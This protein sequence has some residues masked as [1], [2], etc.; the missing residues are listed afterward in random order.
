MK[1]ETLD[2]KDYEK[3]VKTTL[4]EGVCSFIAVHNTKR[5]PALGGIRFYPYA[6]EKEALDDALNLA[7]AMTYKAS[8]AQLPLGGGKAVI[9]GDPKKIK[10]PE[11]LKTYGEFVN[12]LEGKYI[13]AKDVGVT[14]KDMNTISQ[15]CKYVA[16]TTKGG[17]GDPSLMTAFGVYHGL[18]AASQFLWNTPSLKNRKVL[19][20]GLGGVGWAL[21]KHLLDDGA[22][23]WATDTDS[24]ILKHAVLELGIKPASPDELFHTPLEIYSPCAMGQI[25]DAR[26]IPH[27]RSSGIRL[28]AGAANNQLTHEQADGWRLHRERILY[29]PDYVINAGGLINIACELDG[30]YDSARAKRLTEKIYSVLLEIFLKSKKEDRP[31]ALIAQEMALQNI[32]KV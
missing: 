14:L 17:S 30:F 31:T 9:M 7:R 6:T 4:K 21:A 27:L 20:Q 29:A 11:L 24:I 25:I 23:I 10:S 2:T 26:S 19:I 28:I 3:V 15:T 16:G 18:R 12:A 5:G 13:T 22:E 32:R 1:I 8:L